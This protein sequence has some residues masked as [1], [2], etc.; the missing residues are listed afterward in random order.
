[1]RVEVVRMA[2]EHTPWHALTILEPLLRDLLKNKSRRDLALLQLRF[3]RLLELPDHGVLLPQFILP[4]L[5]R[6]LLLGILRRVIKVVP[7]IRAQVHRRQTFGHVVA[8]EDVVPTTFAVELPPRC[9]V[10]E[11]PPYADEQAFV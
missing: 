1:M 9:D 6:L 4:A 10:V 7:R 8:G 11:L 2:S 5:E 3:D